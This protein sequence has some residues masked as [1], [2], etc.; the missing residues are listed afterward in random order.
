M[1]KTAQKGARRSKGDTQSLCAC[2]E[3]A[4]HEMPSK[5]L[6]M[7]VAYSHP[8]VV[9]VCLLRFLDKRLVD[10]LPIDAEI[11]VA[12]REGG[13]SPPN[14]LIVDNHRERHTEAK[15]ATDTAGEAVENSR[16]ERDPARP[17]QQRSLRNPA[18]IAS[19]ASKGA[20]PPNGKQVDWLAGGTARYAARDAAT[21]AVKDAARDAARDIMS[22]TTKSRQLQLRLHPLDDGDGFVKRKAGRKKGYEAVYTGPVF[23][24]AFQ[25]DLKSKDERERLSFSLPSPKFTSRQ[26]AESEQ[27]ESFEPATRQGVDAKEMGN[28][29]G[30]KGGERW[31]RHWIY[32]RSQTREIDASQAEIQR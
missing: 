30:E 28:R 16:N 17:T 11:V 14:S 12:L 9:V 1:H 20:A 8:V 3:K 31:H 21:D 22:S 23:N 25:D 4:L 15:Q 7:T 10:A 6:N 27:Q 29:E 13:I 26:N 32:K 24:R 2:E 5:K 18:S 19:F